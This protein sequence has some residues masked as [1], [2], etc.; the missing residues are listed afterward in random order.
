M[1]K[2][3]NIILQLFWH[4]WIIATNLFLVLMWLG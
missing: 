3:G 2:S 4:F 1:N